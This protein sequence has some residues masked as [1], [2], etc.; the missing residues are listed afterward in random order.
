MLVEDAD[1]FGLA[2]LHQLRGRIG[3]GE[4]DSFCVLATGIDLG[5]ADPGMRLAAERLRAIENT[6]DGF[7]L[8]LVDLDQRGEGQLFGAR[9][10][11]MPQ[12]KMT[13]VLEHQDAI[14]EARELA[15]RVLEDDPELQ[16]PAHRGLE[17]EMRARFPPRSL[18]VLQSG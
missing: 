5:A 6:S 15:V 3:R 18:E 13:R 10:S 12:L 8:A 7:R 9:Q 4:H 1:R 2:Q 11:G 17:R 16:H 14:V